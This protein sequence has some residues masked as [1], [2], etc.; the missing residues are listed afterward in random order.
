MKILITGGAG[1][2]GS[3]IINK[4]VLDSSQTY[5]IVVLD[6]M[7]EQIHGNTPELIDGVTYIIGDVRNESD[8][9]K[10]LEFNPE[11]I[12]HLA[13]ETGTGQSMDEINRYT[14]T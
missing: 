7:L 5:K 4:L 13:S 10:A 1:F 6:N 9:K 2:I 11:V 12:L 3:K 8:W 14:T